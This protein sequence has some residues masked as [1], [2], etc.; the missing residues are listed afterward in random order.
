VTLKINIFVSGHGAYR[1]IRCRL[2]DR[3]FPHYVF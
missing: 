2:G 1:T 3:Q